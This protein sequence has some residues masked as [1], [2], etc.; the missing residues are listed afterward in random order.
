MKDYSCY[1][2]TGDTL[3]L[4]TDCNPNTYYF[5]SSGILNIK[6]ISNQDPTQASEESFPITST[7]ESTLSDIP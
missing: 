3:T 4:D 7:M 6:I 2:G 1:F 5:L